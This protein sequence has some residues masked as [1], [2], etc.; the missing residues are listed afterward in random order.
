MVDVILGGPPC[1]TVSKLRF[2]R[3]GPPPLRARSGPERFALN[4][5][6]AMRELAWGDA[7]L[8][9]RQLW[10][11]TLAC[12]A[13]QRLMLFLKQHPR[14]PEEYKSQEDKNIYPSFYAWPEWQVFRD[15]YN[16][17]EIRMDLGALGYER[18]KPTSLGTNISWLSTLDGLT[19]RQVRDQVLS[20]EAPLQDRTS[21]S[22]GWAAWPL[23]F[24]EEIVKGIVLEL[25]ES[26]GNS[27]CSAIMSR[28][29]GSVQRALREVGNPD[30]TAKFH[31]RMQ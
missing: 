5:T 14:D 15:Q 11:Y 17:R 4:L 9:L 24:K 8:W 23:R 21:Q 6:D 31:I 29:Q 7:V 13:R 10:L 19:D 30:L 2:R 3:P 12:A 28:S 26:S 16:L 18:R 20:A 25:M 1:R 27:T 22:T